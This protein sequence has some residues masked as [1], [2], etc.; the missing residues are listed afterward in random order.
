MFSCLR[1]C[2]LIY[3]YIKR[4][5]LFKQKVSL[6]LSLFMC[7]ELLIPYPV[8]TPHFDPS[9][10]PWLCQ[11]PRGQSAGV[12]GLTVGLIRRPL[13]F[14]PMGLDKAMVE[15]RGQRAGYERGMELGARS[16]YIERECDLLLKYV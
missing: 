13:H 7:S 9:L 6:S 2:V 11:A 10:R 14:D 4:L 1:M 12:G 3:K 15:V 8:H 5:K 16:T